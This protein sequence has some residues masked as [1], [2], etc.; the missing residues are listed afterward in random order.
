M[1]TIA[2]EDNQL[3]LH[4]RYGFVSASIRRTGILRKMGITLLFVV[5][6]TAL[7][8]VLSSYS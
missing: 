6:L 2:R 1:N 7:M 3:M 5:T 4:T 8:L